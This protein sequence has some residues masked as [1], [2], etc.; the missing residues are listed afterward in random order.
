[1]GSGVRSTQGLTFRV[2]VWKLGVE[3][4]GRAALAPG[5]IEGDAGTRFGLNVDRWMGTNLSEVREC[6]TQTQ[7]KMH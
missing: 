7:M 5:A 4:F 2:T 3:S 6:G 1:M